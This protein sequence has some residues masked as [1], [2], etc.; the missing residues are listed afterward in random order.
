MPLL[1]KA[2]SQGIDGVREAKVFR[3]PS[4][5]GSVRVVL[6]GANNTQ[7]GTDIVTKVRARLDTVGLIGRNTVVDTVGFAPLTVSCTYAGTL[8]ETEAKK[9]IT[10]YFYSLGIGTRYTM[11]D[12]YNLFDDQDAIQF[13]TPT[14][15]DKTLGND[16]VYKLTSVRATKKV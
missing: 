9:R 4:G 16:G 6:R 14:A 5:F 3:A 15:S 7:V 13:T 8:T 2:E 10:D 11:Q 12:L 1:Y